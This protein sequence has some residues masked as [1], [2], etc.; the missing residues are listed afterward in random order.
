MTTHRIAA[1]AALVGVLTLGGAGVAVAASGSTGSAS[2]TAGSSSAPSTPGTAK[3]TNVAAKLKIANDLDQAATEGLAL[4]QQA[5]TKATANGNQTRVQRLDARIAKLT[6]RQQKLEARIQKFEAR[7]GS[8]TPATS[9][10][11]S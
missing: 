8:G 10:S 4:L 1:V 3:C 11:T 9:S 2:P 7:C 5:L 6:S